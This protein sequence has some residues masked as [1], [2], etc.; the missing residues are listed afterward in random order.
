MYIREWCNCMAC[1]GIIEV[2]EK[3]QFWIHVE[4]VKDL[5]TNS[6]ALVMI[7]STPTLLEPFEKLIEC[8]KKDGPYGLD[9]SEISKFQYFMGKMSQAL[10]EKHVIT[11]MLP[12]IGHGV[13]EKLETGGMRV[14]DVG[15]GGGSHSSLLAEQYPKAHF[16]GLEI[17]E[18]AIRQAKQRKTKSGAAFNNLEFIQCDAGKMPE[19]WTDS[20]DLVLIFDACH[21]QCRPDLCI[22]EIQRVLKIFGVFAILEINSSGNVHNDRA[23]MGSMAALL[24]GR[25]MLFFP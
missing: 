5:L 21:D 19:I 8:F 14:L 22:R 20:F 18:D 3:E 13:V 25:S 16:V 10:H 24:H 17:G 9:Y 1:G 15:C 23:N 2:N 12:D 4:N 11:D 7:G 6:L